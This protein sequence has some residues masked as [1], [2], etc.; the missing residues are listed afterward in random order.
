MIR[1]TRRSNKSAS[2]LSA[3]ATKNITLE[4]LLGANDGDVKKYSKK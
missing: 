4:V 3:L 2:I 1:I